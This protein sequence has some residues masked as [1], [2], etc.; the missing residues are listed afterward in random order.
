MNPDTHAHRHLHDG[1]GR[2]EAEL[3]DLLD[4]D[5]ALLAPLLEELTGWV[6]DHALAAPRTVVDLGAGT[7][8][9]TLALARRFGS[10]EV[11]AVDR[12]TTML[13]RLRTAASA[14]GLSDR[15]RVVRAD[16]DD[17]WPA[18]GAVDL[19]WAALSLHEVADPERVL[20]D[21]HAAVDP[22]GLLVVVELTALPRF[23]PDD[24]GLADAGL[25]ARC[26]EALARSG[27][28][29][30]P[31]WRPHLVRAGFQVV[32]QRTFTLDAD[33]VPPGTGRYAQA[34]LRQVRSSLDGRLSGEDLDSLDR[35]VADD[36]EHSVLRRPDL[37]LRAGRTAWAARRP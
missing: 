31:D 18:V 25:E 12:S 16:L 8:T 35:L 20:R 11:V 3:A 23:L 7:G 22:G 27:W 36:G 19:A 15:V 9:G 6:A 4:L 10:A 34:Y 14:Q 29:D 33:P 5:A 28:N 37:A 26:H 30:H 24:V 13:G 32:E 17:G 21:V 1:T 2:D